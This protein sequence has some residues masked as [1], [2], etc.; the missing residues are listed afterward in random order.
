MIKLTIECSCG[1]E[2]IIRASNKDKRINTFNEN[3]SKPIYLF[4]E[5]SS[6]KIKCLA[7]N[8]EQEL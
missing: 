2:D 1:N 3:T 7:C 4:T 5:G 8:K 6:I